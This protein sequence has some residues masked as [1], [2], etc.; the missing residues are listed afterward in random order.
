MGRLLSMR[1]SSPP[2]NITSCACA[3][4]DIAQARKHAKTRT[5]M[6]AHGHACRQRHAR[7]CRHAYA[8]PRTY[9]HMGTGMYTPARAGA[10][11]TFNYA[12]ANTHDHACERKPKYIRAHSSTHAPAHTHEVGPHTHARTQVRG[13]T[14]THAQARMRIHVRTDKPVHTHAFAHMKAHAHACKNP[15][16]CTYN[17]VNTDKRDARILINF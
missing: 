15:R 9:T 1:S 14:R 3:A 6:R 4:C 2:R 11:R 13:C 10:T 12:H 5:F 16:T 7:T 8:R 17:N